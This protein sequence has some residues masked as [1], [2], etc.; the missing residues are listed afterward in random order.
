MDIN[1]QLQLIREH[2]AN[3]SI[4]DFERNLQRAGIEVIRPASDYGYYLVPPEDEV[5]SYKTTVDKEYR[6][7]EVNMKFSNR[8]A[9]CSYE[10]SDLMRLAA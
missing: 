8:S 3:I 4:E 5:V 6:G 7:V 2:F 1:E 9:D 10:W